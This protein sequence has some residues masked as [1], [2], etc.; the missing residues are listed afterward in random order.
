M[1]KHVATI[2]ALAGFVSA[3]LLTTGL[4]SFGHVFTATCSA[5]SNA[6]VV[7]RVLPWQGGEAAEI[8]VPATVH[9]VAGT[10]WRAVATGPEAI[11]KHLQF[12]QGK[13][14]STQPLNWCD[15]SVT[16]EL[17][18]PE[19]RHWTLAG[20]GDLTL[21]QLQQDDLDITLAGSGSVTANGKVQHTSAKLAG[22]GDLNLD[23]LEQIDMEL[24]IN[25]S[26]SATAS[27]SVDRSRILIAGSGDA[28]L[29]RLVA[30][31]AR[32]QIWGSGD[33]DIAPVESA[34]VEIGGSGNVRLLRKPRNVQTRIQGSGSVV[35]AG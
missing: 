26:G 1:N 17:T 28:K 27:G 7:T 5:S 11:L 30:K 32:V 34:Q 25:G 10:Q 35:G 15:A 21:E 3:I 19:V 12:N 23:G 16:I 33:A 14:E 31:N 13:L 18:G 22:S 20:S 6:P 2:G 9:F 29:G 8:N 4:P 24:V